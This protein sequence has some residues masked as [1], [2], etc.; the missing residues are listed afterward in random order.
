MAQSNV[1]IVRE[2]VSERAVYEIVKTVYDHLDFL[3]G[4][5]PATKA[6]K[7]E[8]ALRGL[9]LPLHPGAATFYREAGLTIPENL[10][11]KAKRASVEDCR[12]PSPGITLPCRP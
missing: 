8:E 2:D 1:L 4:I 10:L 6:L 5:H 11:P 9:T 12:R 7:L 3:Q